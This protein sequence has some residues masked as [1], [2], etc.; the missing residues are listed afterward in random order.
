MF[1]KTVVIML[2]LIAALVVVLPTFAAAPSFGEAIYADG[3]VWSTKGLSD[4]PAPNDANDQSF[5][6]IFVFSNGE[7][8]QL[9]VAEAAPTNPDFNGGRWNAY[10]ATWTQAGLDAHGTPLPVIES[11]AE[12]MVH[13]DLGHIDLEPTGRYFEC[14]LLPVK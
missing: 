10:S 5:D 8:E 9:P 3:E 6:K 2:A 11:Y 7:E 1:R 13:V 4:L 14:P 12:L